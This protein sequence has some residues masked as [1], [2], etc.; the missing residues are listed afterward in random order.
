MRSCS[1]SPCCLGT[2]ETL[3]RL[4]PGA[5]TVLGGPE[6]A[7]RHNRQGWMLSPRRDRSGPNDR[8]LDALMTRFRISHSRTHQHARVRAAAPRGSGLAS[9][10]VFVLGLPS[11][12]DTAVRG[13]KGLVVAS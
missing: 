13:A 10:L 2:D 8:R 4:W 12:N 1:G 3:P 9:V 7:P 6:F 11:C 5:L